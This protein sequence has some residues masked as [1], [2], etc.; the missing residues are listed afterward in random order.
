MGVGYARGRGQSSGLALCFGGIY[1]SKMVI[2]EE[3][4]VVERRGTKRE[5]GCY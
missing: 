2:I 3:D 4:M 5:M 1:G